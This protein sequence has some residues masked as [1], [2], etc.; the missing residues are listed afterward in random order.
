MFLYLTTEERMK[1]RG[2]KTIGNNEQREEGKDKNNRKNL[3]FAKV[4]RSK[5]LTHDFFLKK[6]KII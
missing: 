2:I 3:M 4:P 5:N 6:K 1:K